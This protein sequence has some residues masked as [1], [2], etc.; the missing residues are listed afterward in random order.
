MINTLHFQLLAAHTLFQKNFLK[1][2]KKLY[3]GLLPGQPKVIDF[4]IRKGSAHQREIA[5]ACLLKPST[6]SLILNKMEAAGLILREKR[7]GNR[8]NRIVSLS[9]KG[10]EIGNKAIVMFR[11]LEDEFCLDMSAEERQ[12]L[13]GAL[14]KIYKHGIE[15]QDE[16]QI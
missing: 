11:E 4:L 9:E 2:F 14:R 6:L 13:A 12:V 3:P 8:K 10:C 7:T 15:L 16:I 1:R 5:D